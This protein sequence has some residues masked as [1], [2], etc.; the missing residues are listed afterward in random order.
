MGGIFLFTK[1]LIELVRISKRFA[2][3]SKGKYNEIMMMNSPRSQ[4]L[5]VLSGLFLL[6]GIWFLLSPHEK[7][8]TNQEVVNPPV[9]VV[10]AGSEVEQQLAQILGKETVELQIEQ[11]TDQHMR[12]VVSFTDEPGAGIFLAAKT[13]TGWQIPFHGNGAIYCKAVEP[14]DFPPD[15]IIDCVGTEDYTVAEVQDLACSQD[16]D[17]LLPADYAIR[18]SCPYESRC[19]ESACT[20]ICPEF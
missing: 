4:I 1:I 10:S 16:T 20:V 2:L 9:V 12:G 11:Q 14:Y 15:M 17:C 7:K 18:S 13:A 8:V 3:V 5:L 19:I 6:T